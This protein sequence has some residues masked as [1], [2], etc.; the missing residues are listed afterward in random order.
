MKKIFILLTSILLLAGCIESVAVIGGGATNG[1]LVQSSLQTAASY[2]IKKSTGETPLGHTINYIKK[3][4]TLSKKNSCSSFANKKDLEI[5][6]KVE[7]KLIS[8]HTKIKEF[9]DKPSKEFALSLQ[10]SINE[11]SK[12]K[13]LD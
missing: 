3:N 10:S 4:R 12:I 9:S 2:G 13:Y 11:K 5:C 8:K 1:K 6:L 7:K